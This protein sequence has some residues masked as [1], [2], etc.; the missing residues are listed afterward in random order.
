M[1]GKE[2]FL[3]MFHRK[4][5]S[6]QMFAKCSYKCSVKNPVNPRASGRLE[7]LEHFITRKNKKAIYDVQGV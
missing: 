2:D 7:H 5:E 3:K 6:V 4:Y 1:E